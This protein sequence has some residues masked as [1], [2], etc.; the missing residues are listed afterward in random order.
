MTTLQKLTDLVQ[1]YFDLVVHLPR[2]VNNEGIARGVGL[3]ATQGYVLHYLHT[4]GSQR[5][6]DLAKVTGLTSSAITQISDGLEKLGT[7]ERLRLKEDRRTVMISITEA[8]V[9]LVEKLYRC[10]VLKMAEALENMSR[11]EVVELLRIMK[12][13]SELLEQR[14]KEEPNE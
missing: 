6:T 13:T 2:L 8:G 5:A 7:I 12:G 9:E 1:S 10:R 4:H 11:E 3:T 14:L